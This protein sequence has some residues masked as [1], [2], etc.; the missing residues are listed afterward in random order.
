MTLHYATRMNDEAHGH[1]Q[2]RPG[3]VGPLGPYA[4]TLRINT[5]KAQAQPNNFFCSRPGSADDASFGRGFVHAMPG[6]RAKMRS[7]GTTHHTFCDVPICSGTGFGQNAQEF[8]QTSES[9]ACPS[10]P[11]G[12]KTPP[13]Y[14]PYTNQIND[15]PSPILAI[16]L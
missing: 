7:A 11:S 3:R 1:A 5:G 15:D 2:A 10:L 16:A 6:A 13:D 4:T 9:Q 14:N 8:M 12:G